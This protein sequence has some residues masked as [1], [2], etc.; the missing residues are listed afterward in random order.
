MPRARPLDLVLR[1]LRALA[2]GTPTR[3]D[4]DEEVSALATATYQS[5]SSNDIDVLN[6]LLDMAQSEIDDTRHTD[7]TLLTTS[8]CMTSW[9]SY[10]W[11]WR[12]YYQ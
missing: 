4:D 11:L 5:H 10:T 1:L 8:L 12:K 2:Q 3:I 9:R 7:G 6:D